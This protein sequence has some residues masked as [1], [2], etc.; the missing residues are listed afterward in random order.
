MGRAHEE[1]ERH[2]PH[3]VEDRRRQD[4]HREHRERRVVLDQPELYQDK[5]AEEEGER[6][7]AALA[8]VECVACGRRCAHAIDVER[9]SSG[10]GVLGLTQS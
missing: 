9:Q 6:E 10:G 1:L 8:E 5:R 7:A 4:Q 2:E 3:Q